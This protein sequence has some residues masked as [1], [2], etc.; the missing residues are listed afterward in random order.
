M[1][2]LSMTPDMSAE[3]WLGAAGWARGSQ[4]CNGIM[5]ALAPKPRNASTKA[6]LRVAAGRL[7]AVARRSANAPMPPFISRKKATMRA[8]SPTCAM[9][10]YQRPA[11]TFS[12]LSCS[13]ITRK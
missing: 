7:A 13:V 1:P 3:T 12:A 6:R 2:N 8:A 10:K 5:P 4:T 11:L 9:P